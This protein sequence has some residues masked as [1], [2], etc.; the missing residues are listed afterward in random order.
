MLPLPPTGVFPPSVTPLDADE[1][2]DE[3][4]LERQLERL[5]GAGVHGFFMLGTSGE[6]TTLT[7]E[8]RC[9]AIHATHKIVARRVPII[10]SAM[11]TSTARV[12][13]NIK[14][15]SDVGVDA[16]AISPPYY[17]A[18]FHDRD[19]LAFFTTLAEKSELPI[20]MYNIPSTTKV[21][22]SVDVIAQLAALDNIIGVK[23]STGNWSHG[24]ELLDRVAERD[25]FSVFIGSHLSAGQGLMYGARGAIMS[26][27]N[28]DPVTCLALF[29]AGRSGDVAETVRCTRRLLRLGM[30]FRHGAQ[31]PALKTALELMGV[32]SHYS[33]HPNL[34]LTPEAVVF[35]E[36]T[37]R[38]LELLE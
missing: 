37:L 25:D 24:L 9:A 7:D 11:D 29:E 13:E 33:T 35:V 17:F 34:P 28:L 23:D 1:R 16:V 15:M 5:I 38:E 27:V 6:G 22:L 10:A 19:M 36:T 8:T 20:F 18:P 3:A 14:G 26:L 2:L 4:G 21:T 30:I 12:L 32:C 31:P